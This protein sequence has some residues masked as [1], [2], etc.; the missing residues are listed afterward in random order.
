MKLSALTFSCLLCVVALPAY[1]NPAATNSAAPPLQIVMCRE[2]VDLEGLIREHKLTPKPKHV[3]WK[4]KGFAA[5]MDEHAVQRLKS[6]SRVR[7]V[8]PDGPVAPCGQMFGAGLMRIGGDHFPVA[9]INGTPKPINVDVAVLDT[10][11][12]P[13]EDLSVYQWWSPFSD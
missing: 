3:W 13:H 4:L 6:D 5:P 9:H 7:S 11:I 1:A 12:N 10:G 8:E 2:G